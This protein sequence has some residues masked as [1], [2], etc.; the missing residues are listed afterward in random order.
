MQPQANRDIPD[1]LAP[2]GRNY[3]EWVWALLDDGID[4]DIGRPFA[5]LKTEDGHQLLTK[6]A[7]TY[8]D[9]QLVV[10]MAGRSKQGT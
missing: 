5:E 4:M 7:A 10:A 3:V 2:D 9:G 1:N 6:D 8:L